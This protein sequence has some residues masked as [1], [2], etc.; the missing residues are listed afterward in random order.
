MRMRAWLRRLITR[1]VAIVPPIIII[2]IFGDSG[3]YQLLILSQVIFHT[4]LLLHSLNEQIILALQLPFA[5]LPLIKFTS[6]AGGDTFIFLFS[7]FVFLFTFPSSLI[8]EMGSFVNPLWVK[9]CSYISASI[10]VALNLY[11]WLSFRDSWPHHRWYILTIV[12]SLFSPNRS[13]GVAVIAMIFIIPSLIALLALLFYIVWRWQ[14]DAPPPP[15]DSCAGRRRTNTLVLV[16]IRGFLALKSGIPCVLDAHRINKKK[17][18]KWNGRS[19][20]NSWISVLY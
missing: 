13:T 11:Y 12:I 17:R 8:S 14:I 10:I 2:F 18:G 6:N 9:V 4:L 7:I 20:Q 15:R 5:I 19:S 16:R 3:T 1:L